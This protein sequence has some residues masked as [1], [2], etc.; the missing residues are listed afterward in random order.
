MVPFFLWASMASFLPCGHAW[1][2]LFPMDK[3]SFHYHLW[4]SMVLFRLQLFPVGNHG[5][6]PSLWESIV[7]IKVYLQ[8]WSPLFSMNKHGPHY[9]LLASVVSLILYGQ[10]SFILNFIGNHGPLYFLCISLV[11]LIPYG[12]FLSLWAIMSPLFSMGK[13]S[14][15]HSLWACIVY[16]KVY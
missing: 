6:L 7:Y 15:I 10:A 11:Y 4:G 1:S 12:H 8:A 14:F 13:L 9:F 2:L 16:I 5:F 3:H